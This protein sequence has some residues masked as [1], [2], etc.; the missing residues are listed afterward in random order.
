MHVF[1]FMH[2]CINIPPPDGR[3][4]PRDNS[5][6]EDDQQPSDKP[7]ADSHPPSAA[8]GAIFLHFCHFP[9]N[10][11]TVILSAI[12]IFKLGK[13]FIKRFEQA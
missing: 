13:Q 10:T 5:E 3:Q 12:C 4:Q 2:L 11:V 8:E 6:P 7:G 1:F 9:A